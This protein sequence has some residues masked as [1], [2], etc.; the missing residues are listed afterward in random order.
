MS[1]YSNAFDFSANFKVKVAG[2]LDP[3]M[4]A[5]SKE[6]LIDKNNCNA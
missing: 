2:A 1:K 5:A 4:V 6:D 3:R